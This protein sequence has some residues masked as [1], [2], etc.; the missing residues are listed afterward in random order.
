[1]KKLILFV[2]LFS[3]LIPIGCDDNTF[4]QGKRYYDGFCGN[5]HGENGEG[6]RGLIPP[7]AKSDYLSKNRESLACVIHIGQKGAILVNGVGYGQQEMPAI[8]KLTDFEI[9]NILNYVGTSWG[10]V[11]KLWTVE[12]IREGLKACQ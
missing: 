3:T 5:C 10:N 2:F 1:L 11:E 8:A 12:E 7:L 4:K 6:L 9:T